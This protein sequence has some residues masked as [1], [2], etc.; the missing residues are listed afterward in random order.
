MKRVSSLAHFS[1]QLPIL[2]DFKE[3]FIY[4]GYKY[5]VLFMYCKC[6]LPFVNSF[7]Q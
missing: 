7:H 3:L 1:L 2:I 4:S 6:L 5:L